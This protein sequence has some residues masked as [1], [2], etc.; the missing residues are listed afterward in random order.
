MPPRR[1]LN[2]WLQQREQTVAKVGHDLAQTRHFKFRPLRFI[3]TNVNRYRWGAANLH[4]HFRLLQWRDEEVTEVGKFCAVNRQAVDRNRLGHGLVPDDGLR[5]RV[6]QARGED[7]D[8]AVL[9]YPVE[10]ADY[11]EAVAA[12]VDRIGFLVW[13]AELDLCESLGAHSSGGAIESF[14]QFVVDRE[15]IGI[16][17]ETWE[18]SGLPML[19]IGDGYGEV[20]DGGPHVVHCVS[21]DQ[22]QR[23]IRLA[24]NLQRVTPAIA[25]AIAVSLS[26]SDVRIRLRVSGD[27]VVEVVQ[28]SFRPIELEP[29][30]LH[31]EVPL[32]RARREAA[33]TEDQEGPRDTGADAGELLP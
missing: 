11:G 6:Q 19:R 31:S 22:G 5:T 14:P 24:P 21:E 29:P 9:V 1:L 3:Q 13:L 2:E 30:T 10:L 25:M 18:G 8:L 28:V 16:D 26:G 33:D 12:A 23:D 27:L 32:D 15:L 4:V 20:I 7:D 17:G